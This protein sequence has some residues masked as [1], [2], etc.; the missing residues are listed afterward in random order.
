MLVRVKVFLPNGAPVANPLIELWNPEWPE[1]SWG[2]EAK[3]D[4]AGWYTI[5]LPEGEL[6][7]LFARFYDTSGRDLCAGPTALVASANM[8]PVVL[9]LTGTQGSCFSQ[10]ITEL[11]WP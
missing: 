11:P 6:F 3:K 4:E 2:P 9:V 1:Y 8:Q 10:H 7:N 5:Q